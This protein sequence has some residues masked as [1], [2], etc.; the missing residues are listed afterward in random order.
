MLQPGQHPE[1]GGLGGRKASC[2]PLHRPS[3]SLQLAACILTDP[4]WSFSSPCLGSD[5]FCMERQRQTQ[6]LPMHLFLLLTC[7]ARCLPAVPSG[8]RSVA[9]TGYFHLAL[10]N[11]HFFLCIISHLLRPFV[12]S[13]IAWSVVRGRHSRASFNLKQH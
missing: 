8:K 6:P 1:M 10:G 5:C 11:C 9:H 3:M 12:H 2:S 7:V 13:L 4:L